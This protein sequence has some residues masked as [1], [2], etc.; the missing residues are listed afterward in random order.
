MRERIFYIC[1]IVL[2]IAFL[3]I[4][5]RIATSDLYQ[6]EEYYQLNFYNGVVTEILERN[7]EVI[8]D[9]RSVEVIFE[10]RLTSGGRRG[11]IIV[12][13]QM[14]ADFFLVNEREVSVG[15]RVVVLDAPWDNTFY[16]SDFNRINYIAVIGIVFFALII[17]FAKMKGFNAIIAL[18]FTC[19]A[20][21]WIFIPAILAGKNIYVTTIII[22]VYAII[23]TLLIVIG[24]SKKA[25]SAMLGCLGG[26]IIAGILMLTLDS[27]LQLT[28][29]VDRDTEFLLLLHPEDPIN[30][31]AIIFAGVILGAVGAIMD[32]A[33]SISSSLWEL[34]ETGGVS[35]FSSILKSGI[36]IGKDILGTMLNTLILA[37]IGSSLSLILLLNANTTDLIALLNREMIIVEFL[38]AL[39]GSFGMLLTIPLTAGICGWLYT[40]AFGA[41]EE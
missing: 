15:D 7:E 8:W 12:A 28:G 19:L 22:C 18:G 39:V 13:E 34:K 4:G 24:P 30:L 40:N 21:F 10:T 5:N 38:R 14:V 6:L 36:N 25:L 27:F 35:D 1:V 37:Y 26:V 23:S 16:F 3:F 33:M 41:V 2:S 31:R 9:T 11:E 32:V 29:G 20:I 17:L